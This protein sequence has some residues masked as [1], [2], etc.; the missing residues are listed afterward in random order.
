MAISLNNH[1][2]R[3]K[4]LENKA[5]SYLTV[6][7]SE[8]GYLRDTSGLMILWQKVTTSGR[9]NFHT[10]FPTTCVNVVLSESR[11]QVGS[12]GDT[13]G[14]GCAIVSRTQFNVT[15][16]WSTFTPFYIIAIGW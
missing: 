1:E 11:V 8:N 10:A 15:Q 9:Q 6:S 12:G 3:I 13:A 2:T 16:D 4:A 7:K 14:V 5:T